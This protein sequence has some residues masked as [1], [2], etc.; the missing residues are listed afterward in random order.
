MHVAKTLARRNLSR[1]I[2]GRDP[3]E[4]TRVIVLD[5]SPSRM[6]LEEAAS[7][8]FHSRHIRSRFNKRRSYLMLEF[9]TAREKLTYLKQLPQWLWNQGCVVWEYTQPEL[10]LWRLESMG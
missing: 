3:L 6:S 10:E 7:L 2:A 5:L 9:D 1:H 4:K 8:A